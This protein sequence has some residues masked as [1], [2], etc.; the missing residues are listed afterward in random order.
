M[1]YLPPRRFNAQFNVGDF[2]YQ[3]Q[4]I[5]Y[6]EGD[7]LYSRPIL[8]IQKSLAGIF[9]SV[10]TWASSQYFSSK[11]FLNTNSG[12][13]IS[14]SGI[15]IS[16]TELGYLDNISTNIQTQLTT[17]TYVSASTGT[18]TATTRALLGQY[19]DGN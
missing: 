4:N 19:P 6:G 8:A 11:L 12:I 3:D 2:D 16:P 18:T 1:Q 7:A 15:Q 14:D 10:N 5:T 13:N 9:T 17:N